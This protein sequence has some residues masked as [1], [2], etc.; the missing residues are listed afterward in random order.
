MGR[1][2]KKLVNVLLDTGSIH[3]FVDPG[4]VQRTGFTVIEEPTF[5]VDGRRRR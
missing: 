1:V 3:N 5:K 4:V 2:N